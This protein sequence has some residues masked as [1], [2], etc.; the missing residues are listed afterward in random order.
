MRKANIFLLLF[1]IIFLV[2]GCD[3]K[4]TLIS[5]TTTVSDL[6][7]NK[8]LIV[9]VKITK[10]QEGVYV[11]NVKEPADI[12]GFLETIS[13]IPVD[14][15]SPEQDIAFMDKGTKF[16]EKGLYSVDLYAESAKLSGRFLIWPDGKIYVI[17]IRSMNSEQRTESY[18]SKDF[19]PEIYQ[20]VIDKTKE[21]ASKGEELQKISARYWLGDE[22]EKTIEYYIKTMEEKN[23]DLLNDKGDT[24][25]SGFQEYDLMLKLILAK[26]D[27]KWGLYDNTGA[28]ILPHLYEEI[29]NYEMLDGNK[30]NGLVGVKKNGLWGAIDQEGEIVIQPEFDYIDLNYYEEVEPFIKVKKNGKFGYL[31]REGK[32][33]VDTVWDTAFMDVLN[34]PE[35]IIFVR[36][37]DKWGGIR[38]E[39]EKAAPVDWSLIPSEEAQLTFNNWKYIH[40]SDFYVN[41]IKDGKT[42]ISK[43]T[44]RFFND[45]FRKNSRR[46]RSLPEFSK[47]KNP[48][49]NELAKFVYE[50]TEYNQEDRSIT[51]EAFA[52][53]VKKYFGNLNYTDQS[54]TYLEYVNGNYIPKGWS[55][56]GFYIYELTELAKQKTSE[57][58]DSWKARITGYYFY[59]LD[60]DPDEASLKS[61][62]AQVVWSKMKEEEYKGLNF[63]QACDLLVWNNPG[64]SLE[65]AGEWLIEFTVN[66]P[67]GDIHFTYLSCEKKGFDN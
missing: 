57:G 18:L 63:W 15:L 48:D 64:D 9:N 11:C 40:Q 29:S 36:Q 25:L 60:G 34:V 41:Q 37:R 58:K 1:I 56:H 32:P 51:K 24:I 43:N 67:L 23:R 35:D 5:Q 65:P 10:E 2:V 47:K 3:K 59:E 13:K 44:L 33:M 54:S 38:I 17:D 12:K 42:N 49:F 6:I 19:H 45:Y 55:D 50:N 22:G 39:N 61:K 52:E 62:N 8:D 31:T 4:D 30:A 21:M 26:R 14:K 7:Y 53:T 20:W 27:G 66:D 16:L 28:K 46:L